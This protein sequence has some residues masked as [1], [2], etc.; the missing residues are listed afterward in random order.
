VWLEDDALGRWDGC[1]E[2]MAT[3]L[4][5]SARNLTEIG[6]EID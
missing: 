4:S 5:D 1:S 3:N 2:T 6:G